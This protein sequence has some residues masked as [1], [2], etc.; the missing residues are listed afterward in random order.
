VAD[1]VNVTDAGQF[2][3]TCEWCRNSPATHLVIIDYCPKGRQGAERTEGKVCADCGH[4]TTV[5][6]PEFVGFWLYEMVPDRCDDGPYDPEPPPPPTLAERVTEILS[7]SGYTDSRSVFPG[8][9]IVTEGPGFATTRWLVV[10]VPWTDASDGERLSLL[11]LMAAE[12]RA[13]RLEVREMGR[14]LQV[15]DRPGDADDA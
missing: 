8:G 3:H 7:A 6:P 10:S 1:G 14:H 5:L 13:H 9:F 15:R 11:E 12:L 4:R 2:P